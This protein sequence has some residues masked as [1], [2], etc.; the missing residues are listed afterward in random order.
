M[1]CILKKHYYRETLDVKDIILQQFQ[2]GNYDDFIFKMTITSQ[3]YG[4][5]ARPSHTCKIGVWCLS[6]FSCHITKVG[7]VSDLS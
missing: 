5:L 6:N 4:L 2:V 3:V 7:S 1:G